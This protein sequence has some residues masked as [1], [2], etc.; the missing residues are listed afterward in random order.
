MGKMP[1]AQNFL[2]PPRMMQLTLPF[3]ELNLNRSFYEKIFK[4]CYSPDITLYQG[5]ITSKFR[6]Q[7]LLF[8]P[9]GASEMGSPVKFH[10]NFLKN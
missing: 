9:Y 5:Q 6:E 8:M 3:D 2:I 10:D 7:K 4:Q 1:E